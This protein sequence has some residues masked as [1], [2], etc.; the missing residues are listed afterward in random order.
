[1]AFTYKWSVTSLKVRDEVNEEGETLTNAVVQ[2]YWKLEGTDENG[3][4]G[5][6]SGATPFTAK[7]VPAGSFVAFAELTEETV[8]GWIKNVV[9]GDQS[10]KEHIDRQIQK[11][12]DQHVAQEKAGGDLPWATP[13]EP[14]PE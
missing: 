5:E 2:T 10:Y 11:S 4:T 14:A 3:N 12:I 1:M 6:F 13:S 9:N 8:L 7:N